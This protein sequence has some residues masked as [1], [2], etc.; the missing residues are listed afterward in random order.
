MLENATVQRAVLR[1]LSANQGDKCPQRWAVTIAANDEHGDQYE[2]E[3]EVY[4]D[5]VEAQA[6]ADMINRILGAK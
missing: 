5:S 1:Q 6:L 4:A 2:I 3:I